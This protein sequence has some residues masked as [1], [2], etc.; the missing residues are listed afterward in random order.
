MSL[1]LWEFLKVVY[2][3]IYGRVYSPCTHLRIPLLRRPESL[4]E[5]APQ[6]RLTGI[7]VEE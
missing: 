3:R 6:I 5:A 1:D 7:Q 2:I 4:I